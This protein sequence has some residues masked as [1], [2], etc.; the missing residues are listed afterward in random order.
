MGAKIS[1]GLRRAKKTVDKCSDGVGYFTKNADILKLQITCSQ[2]NINIF[3][4][5]LNEIKKESGR[6]I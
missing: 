3:Q 5:A 4:N 2:E 6:I 1:T